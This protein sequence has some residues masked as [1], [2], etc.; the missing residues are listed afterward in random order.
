MS[1]TTKFRP[2]ACGAYQSLVTRNYITKFMVVSVNEFGPTFCLQSVLPCVALPV[3][4][5]C[6]PIRHRYDGYIT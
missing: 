1:T 4:Y 2:A 5:P 3:D 6:H